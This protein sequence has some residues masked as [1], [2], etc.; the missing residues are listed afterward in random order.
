MK[1]RRILLPVVLL[2]SCNV[3]G[4]ASGGFGAVIGIVQD[5][6]RQ[7]IPDTTVVL[8]NDALGVELT[9]NTSGDGW[10][11]APTVTPS[12]GYKLK[13]TRAGFATWESEEFPVSTGEKVSFEITLQMAENA[14]GEARGGARL[15]EDTK[16]GISVTITPLAVD[17]TPISDRRLNQL[18]PLAPMMNVVNSQPGLLVFHGV[19]F[20]NVFLTDGINTTNNYFQIRRGATSQVSLDGVQDFHVESAGFSAEFGGAM[21]GIVNTATRSGT[22]AYHGEAYEFYRNR[23]LQAEDRYAMG[24]NTRQLQHQAGANLGGPLYGS[25]LFFF[26]NGEFLHR[27]GQGLNRI[28]N[29]LIADPAGTRILASNCQAT[30]AQCSVVTRVLQSQMNVLVPLWDHS[31]RGLARIDYRRSDRNSFSVVGNAIEW[32]AP[33]LAETEVVAPNGGLLGQPTVRERTRFA[34]AGWTVTGASKTNDARIGWFQDRISEYPTAAP[35]LVAGPVGISIAGTTVGASLPYPAVL[36]SEHRWDFVENANFLLGSHA[37]KVGVEL[38]KTTDFAHYLRNAAGLYEYPTLTAF[39]QDFPLTGQRNYTTFSQTLGNADRTFD[40][41]LFRAY[42]E[43][44]WRPTGRITVDFALHYERPRL[45]QPSQVNPSFYQT[46]AINPP[47]LDLSPRVGVAY[48]VNERTVVRA[49][50]GFYYAPYSGQLLDTLFLGNALGQ[51]GISVN[52]NQSGA[53][54]HPS[55]FQ[56]TSQVPNGTTNVA[57]A[58]AKFRNPYAQETTVAIERHIG[59]GT[60]VTL[61]LLHSRGIKL[62]TTQDANLAA[63]TAT[64]TYTIANAARQATGT[65]TTQVWT[66]K[67]NANFAHA[68]QVENGGSSW[69]NGASLQVSKRMSHGISVAASYTFS[70]SIDNTGQSAPFATVSSATFNANYPGDKGN[71]AFDQRHRASIQ[72]VW[73]PAPKGNSAAARHL[74]SGWQLSTMTTLASS[75]FAT[76]VVT[77]EGQQFSGITMAYTSSLNGSGGWARVPFL[78]IDNLKTGPEYNVDARLVRTIPV[79]ERIQVRLMFEAFNAFNTQY[80]TSVNTIAYTAMGLPP[81][82]TTGTRSGTLVPAPGVGNGIASHGYPD[83][84]NARRAQVALRIVF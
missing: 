38:L 6:A 50:F 46:A 61:S 12:P 66:G 51:T 44:T 55:L 45:P 47:G 26:V 28:T 15:V 10:F 30:A 25:K 14:E 79:T 3:W 22:T 71:S 49:G 4:Q 37:I 68:Y 75:Q 48:L 40:S 16:S 73:Q 81:G 43:D 36:P 69:Y 27:N 56:L 23:S 76:P 5:P 2:C 33:I 9:M 59:A 53:P 60:T 58:L 19:P 67:V 13:A 18:V 82:V 63:P 65:Y 8:S 74:L 24:Y 34:K 77:V 84:T 41:R 78:P 52:P 57:F 17:A 21:G 80:N 42:A 64:Q 35:Q 32:H 1:S 20:S 72:W 29:P 31:V 70:H 11:N 54:V 7:G 83:G 39:A 62:W